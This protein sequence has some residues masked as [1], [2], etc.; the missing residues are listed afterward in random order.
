MK[1]RELKIKNFMS[2]RKAK[3]DLSH[4]GIYL[5]EGDV[6]DSDVFSSNGAGKSTIFEALV[7]CLFGKTIRN[8]ESKDDVVNLQA[9]GDCRVSQVIDFEDGRYKIIRYRSHKKHENS[10]M[11]LR[12]EQGRYVDLTGSSWKVNQDLIDNLLDSNYRSFI[13]SVIF[14]QGSIDRFANATDKVRKEILERLLSLDYL[15]DAY[16]K[17]SG[18]LKQ[19]QVYVSNSEEYIVRLESRLDTLQEAFV[20]EKTQRESLI[21]DM[22]L[23]LSRYVYQIERYERN[24]SDGEDILLRSLDRPDMLGYYENVIRE[25][26]VSIEEYDWCKPE[27]IDK[28][29]SVSD[30]NYGVRKD[31]CKIIFEFEGAVGSLCDA[32]G[33]RITKSVARQRILELSGKIKGIDKINRVL[34]GGI[35]SLLRDNESKVELIKRLETIELALQKAMSGLRDRQSDIDVRVNDIVN[36]SLYL[37]EHIQLIRNRKAIV[38]RIGGVTVKRLGETEKELKFKRRE[39]K[40]HQDRSELYEFWKVGFSNSGIKSLILDSVV[41]FLNAQSNK[42][43]D[44]LTAGE[45]EIEFNTESPLKSGAVRDKLSVACKKV[46]G[47]DNYGSISGGEKRRA[48]ICQSLAIRELVVSRGAKGINLLVLDEVFDSLDPVGIEKTINLIHELNKRNSSIFVITHSP[49]L[50]DEFDNVITVENE[51]GV[52]TLSQE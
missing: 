17:A 10:V 21:S 51:N 28:L 19:R 24:I 1:F 40:R 41:P 35:N 34:Q 2:F 23:D 30:M 33:Q 4:N 6:K 39:L 45:I 16:D 48:E 52:S 38:K 49:N 12:V 50:K 20:R 3:L 26:T 25:L 37:S 7:W 22:M 43:S 13:N 44:I 11:V 8:L 42:F 36:D 32:C 9:G 47:G 46:S 29:K 18:V 14:G 15:S 27:D 5:I 31:L